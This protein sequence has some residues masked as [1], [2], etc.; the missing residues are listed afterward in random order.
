MSQSKVST[1]PD[2]SPQ[3][4]VEFLG[5]YELTITPDRLTRPTSDTVEPIY[6]F[7]VELVTG[8]TREDIEDAVTISLEQLQTRDEDKNLFYASSL[9]QRILFHHIT[10][11]T[12]A[13]GI[14]DFLMGDLIAPKPGRTQRVLS[15]IVNFLKYAMQECGP[16]VTAMEKEAE[17]KNAEL[18]QSYQEL[19]AARKELQ[20]AKAKIAAE[21]PICEKHRKHIAELK[22]KILFL[23]DQHGSV[24]QDLQLLRDQKKELVA[25][26][27]ALNLEIDRVNDLV[28]RTKSNVVQSPERIKRRI[29]EM[30]DN[31]KNDRD[32][33]SDLE[34]RCRQL[35]AKI[36]AFS[37]IAHDVR[38]CYEQLQV[39][40]QA[41]EDRVMVTRDLNELRETLQTREIEY[42]ELELRQAR[43]QKQLENANEKLA[44]VS[45]HM[46][47]KRAALQHTNER[48]RREYDEWAVERAGSE[49]QIRKFRQ[50]T[51]EVQQK[52]LELLETSDRELNELLDVYWDLQQGIETY[53]TR[54]GSVMG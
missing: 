3:E 40:A 9:N 50:L 20:D 4:I 30:S 27:Q 33:I 19:E 47:D 8:I 45:R 11:V 17:A 43:M 10:R 44:H 42:K 35:Q 22:A 6:S 16:H 14:D 26:K 51:E 24:A 31:V 2:V 32:A 23:R 1:Y 46:G 13:S 7:C 36:N 12:K 38:G 29:G 49:E 41:L 15:A 52:K 28:I 48:L 25:R 54:L 18:A 37:E 21:E 53:M 39:V 34:S 5:E